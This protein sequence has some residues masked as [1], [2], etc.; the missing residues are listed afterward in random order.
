MFLLIIKG[1]YCH[2]IT[3]QAQVET[4]IAEVDCNWSDWSSCSYYCGGDPKIET[5][6]K[7][8]LDVRPKGSKALCKIPQ[9]PC[10]TIACTGIGKA[11][12]KNVFF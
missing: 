5:K 12:E 7:T 8:L 4:K 2:K 6:Y 11:S 3:L 9:Q 10:G 1:G